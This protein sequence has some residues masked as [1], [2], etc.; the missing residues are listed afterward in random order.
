M[1][2]L[3]VAEI[4]DPGLG[5]AT[6]TGLVNA[7]A[8]MAAVLAG[9]VVGRFADRGHPYIIGIFCAA[10]AALFLLPQ[11]FLPTVW[12]LIPFVFLADFCSVGIDPIMNVLLS[13]QVP[14]ERRGA[15]FGLAGS[16]R[17]L[18]WSAGAMLG[19]TLAAY[20][21]FAAVFINSAIL[22]LAIAVILRA[23]S[24]RPK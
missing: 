24:P 8:G 1:Y 21:D 23:R 22:F 10:A 9:I 5:V 14:V 18:G 19:G 12:V 13:R 16:A 15:A 2:P 11:G 3:L 7:A 4:A 17:G 20:L 6:Q